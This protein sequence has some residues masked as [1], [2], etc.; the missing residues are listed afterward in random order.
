MR[1]RQP[2]RS[3]LLPA[4]RDAVEDAPGDDEMPARVVVAE[5][6]TQAMV[7]KGGKGAANGRRGSDEDRNRTAGLRR[8]HVLSVTEEK[9]SAG[10][11]RP[12]AH[13]GVMTLIGWIS[14]QP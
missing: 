3:N 4:R 5:R 6:E 9:S 12:E 14:I 10:A 1:Q 11:R 2:H 7:V 13:C 8:V